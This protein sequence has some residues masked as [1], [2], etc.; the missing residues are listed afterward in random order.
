MTTLVK[1]CG[2]SDQASLEVVCE[3]GADFLGF[4][5]FLNSPRNVSLETA[6]KLRALVPVHS[7]C[8]VVA[9]VVDQS[10]TD[11]E[12]ILQEINPDFFQIHGDH[13]L[14]RVA[15]LRSKLGKPLIKAIS[16]SCEEEVR[17]GLDY[18]SPGHLADIVLYDAKPTISS[19][20]PGGNGLQFDWR[21]LSP[22]S[23]KFPF[24]LAGGLNPDN[25]A[26]AIRS[27]GATMVDVSSGVEK[28]LGKKDHELIRHFIRNAKTVEQIKVEK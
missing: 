18:L 5:F 24:A 6:K 21:I 17:R 10:D 8:K 4:V 27:T 13:S 1:I 15:S 12:K 26:E 20:L 3:S 19:I 9:L 14:I 11:I 7:K 2:I 25:V 23:G 16:V 22:V 28:A